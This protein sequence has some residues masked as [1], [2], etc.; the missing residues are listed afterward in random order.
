MTRAEDLAT[1]A[2]IVRSVRLVFHRLRAVGEA[3]HAGDAITMPMRGVMESL[4]AGG[5]QTVRGWRR[6]DR[7]RASTFMPRSTRSRPAGWCG[8]RPIRRT[9]GHPTSC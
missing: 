5:A 1:M 8:H 6:R 2:D 7:S 9:E 4:S 3:L